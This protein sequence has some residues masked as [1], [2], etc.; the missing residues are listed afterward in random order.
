MAAAAVGHLLTAM[1]EGRN[2]ACYVGLQSS[3]VCFTPLAHA[4]EE[5]DLT[6]ER[7]REQW[8]L[9]LRDMVHMLAQPKPSAVAEGK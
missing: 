3:K 7:P 9:G 2:D 4:I 5:M 6:E 8:W 1:H